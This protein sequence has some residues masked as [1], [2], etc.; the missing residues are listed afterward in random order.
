LPPANASITLLAINYADPG[1]AA[2][3]LIGWAAGRRVKSAYGL[4]S[5]MRRGG[6]GA[7]LCGLRD[8]AASSAFRE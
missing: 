3:G 6:R 2:T 5:L 7:A 1:A 8:F 4:F